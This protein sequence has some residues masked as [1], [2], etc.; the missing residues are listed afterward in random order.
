MKGSKLFVLNTETGKAAT[1]HIIDRE[2]AEKDLA[3]TIIGKVQ[4]LPYT[5]ECRTQMTWRSFLLGYFFDFID[6]ETLRRDFEFA[7]WFTEELRR[8]GL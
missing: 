8:Q 3:K 4:C 1:V 7:P 5:G 2:D 6:D